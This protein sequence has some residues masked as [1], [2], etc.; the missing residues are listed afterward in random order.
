MAKAHYALG[1]DLGGTKIL[2]G[3]VE[4]ATG[5]ILVSAKRKTPTAK[6]TDGLL[7][8][9]A[10]L[11]D[12]VSQTP[13]LPPNLKLAGIGIGAAG[14]I[15]RKE[16]A[17]VAAP[18]LGIPPNYPLGRLLSERFGL[19]VALGND[20]EAAT[21][22]ELYFG[23]G[24]GY[25]HFACVFV[26]TGIGGGLVH[27]G[28]LMKGTTGTAGEV[29]HMVISAGGRHCGCGGRG[30]LEAYSSRTAITRTL[31]GELKRGKPSILRDLLDIG[32][33]PD[34][35]SASSIAIRSK[36]IAKAVAANDYLTKKVLD[37]AAD[38]L[39]LGVA[40]LINAY[41]PQRIILGGGLIEAVDVFFEQVVAVAMHEAL[42]LST[43]KVEIVRTKL[44][45]FSGLVGSALLA[46]QFA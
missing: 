22:G 42:S 20:V 8:R 26:G 46:G 18:N 33:L 44:G 31:L 27:D 14:Q 34:A 30:H 28:K 1:I 35:S 5:R 11:L 17:I 3:I 38:Y 19:P 41:N 23:S 40:S 25:D 4:L 13:D 43:S 32:T 24:Q 6:S 39:G 21:L 7:E 10:E 36:V 16:G 12:E 2:G 9:I 37:E 15:N 45:D 29:G